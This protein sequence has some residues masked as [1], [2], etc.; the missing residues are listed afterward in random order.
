MLRKYFWALLV[1]TLAF[2]ACGEEEGGKSKAFRD[3]ACANGACENIFLYAP[4]LS[5]GDIY[6]FDSD[7][8]LVGSMTAPSGVGHLHVHNDTLLAVDTTSNGGKMYTY[9]RTIWPM[10]QIG[11]Y[12]E[13]RIP[14]VR[15]LVIHNN[16]GYAIANSAPGLVASVDLTRPVPSKKV[17]DDDLIAR[18][19]PFVTVKELGK[20][21]FTATFPRVGAILGQNLLLTLEGPTGKDDVGNRLI[22]ISLKTGD[23]VRELYFPPTHFEVKTGDANA[24]RPF[25]LVVEGTKAYV[26]LS[27]M[28]ATTW[29]PAGP[30]YVAIVEG[31]GRDLVLEKLIKVAG[32]E[33]AA[34]MIKVGDRLYVACMGDLSVGGALAIVDTTTQTVL[35]V[36][37]GYRCEDKP[38]RE[39]CFVAA[40]RTIARMGD[41]IIMGDSI[42]GR[43]FAFDLDGNPV[44]GTEYGVTVCSNACGFSCEA[45]HPVAI[46]EN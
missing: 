22:E 46:Q 24:A 43:I 6:K 10:T 39:D 13:L 36:Q 18:V 29:G 20:T 21:E 35:R 16:K 8:G 3:Q 17:G 25:G 14:S 45:G 38:G 26:A 9:D 11:L 28:N 27:N 44:A 31:S 33:G 4:C 30:S 15:D 42:E 23:T 7:F 1:P 2:A 12:D 34:N 40:P 41:K 37:N 5:T 32:C 19:A